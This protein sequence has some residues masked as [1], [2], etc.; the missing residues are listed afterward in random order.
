[1]Q[2]STFCLAIIILAVVHQKLFLS[3]DA[4]KSSQLDESVQRRND[5]TDDLD[6][7]NFIQEGEADGK[8]KLPA[9]DSQ[10]FTNLNGDENFGG[11]S[12]ENDDDD[13]DDDDEVYVRIRRSPRGGRGGGGRGGGGRSGGGRSGK[14]TGRTSVGRRFH[15]R[16]YVRS[17]PSHPNVKTRSI[18]P[19]FV[20]YRVVNPP[21]VRRTSTKSRRTNSRIN[22]PRRH[23]NVP[24]GTHLRRISRRLPTTNTQYRSYRRTIRIVKKKRSEL[25]TGAIIGIVL[26]SLAGVALL[27]GLG[28][29]FCF[30]RKR[31]MSA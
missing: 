9:K 8:L 23:P 20:N 19:Q 21:N 13:D 7:L 27:A 22:I 17:L 30:H 24:S 2:R 15:F 16:P 5:R 1:M 11:Q 31:N 4:L 18:S 26:G 28:L 25:S 12:N 6:V 10:K 3:A 14:S 29:W